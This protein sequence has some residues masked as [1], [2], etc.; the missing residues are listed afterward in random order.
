MAEKHRSPILARGF[1]IALLIATA[2][3][4]VIP[5]FASPLLQGAQWGQPQLGGPYVRSTLDDRL[6]FTY[7]FYWYDWATQMHFSSPECDHCVYHIWD[8]ASVSWNNTVWHYREFKDMIAAGIDVLMPVYWGGSSGGGLDNWSKQGLGPMRQALDQLRV[9]NYN[10]NNVRNVTYPIPK[11]AMFFDTTTM[12]SVYLD[13]NGNPATDLTNATH[14]RTFYLIMRDF[15]SYFNETHL[16]Q[17]PNA[18]NPSGP[19]A[20]IVWFYGSGWLKKVAQSALDYCNAEFLKEFGHNLIFVGTP[21][22]ERDCPRI[23]GTYYWGASIP[24]F[25]KI[26][27]SKIRI[28]GLGCGLFY[29]NSTHGAVCQVAREPMMIPRSPA[30]YANNWTTVNGWNP[31][32][33]A[34]ETWNEMHEGTSI[35]RTDEYGDLYI[36]ETGEFSTTFHALA[37]PPGGVFN[38]S[39]NPAFIPGVILVGAISSFL[40][41]RAW[42]D[43]RGKRVPRAVD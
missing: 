24:G 12:M 27:T 8:A 35:C 42:Y 25:V 31:N 22:W 6:L 3:A 11:I 21:G 17:V 39:W 26:D 29:G 13:A 14:V 34:L 30:F 40:L 32:W 28:A 15:F 19:S 20:Y 5:F 7:Y 9:E 41:G 2:G 10:A 1:V 18:D 16:L 38:L 23:E 33:I 4:G 36:N 37:L 43:N